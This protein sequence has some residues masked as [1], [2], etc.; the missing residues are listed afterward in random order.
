[1]NELG[2]LHLVLLPA[3]LGLLGFVEP[4][5]I[6]SSLLFV[7]FLEGK[8]RA[9]KISQTALFTATR[10]TF[11]G[12]LGAAAV[13]VG[14]AFAS[15]QRLAWVVLGIAYTLLGLLLVTGRYVWFTVPGRARLSSMTGPRGSVALGLIFGLNIPACA[16]PLLAALLAMSAAT[17]TSGAAIVSGFVSLAVFGLALSLPLLAAVFFERARRLLDRLAGGAARFPRWAGALLIVLGAWS[18]YYA[19]SVEVSLE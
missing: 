3:G 17:G 5:S 16:V 2:L 11:V 1:M 7:K 19:A 8:G 12:T 6:G 13:V 15:Y 4:C 9:A 18:I 14:S 10:A